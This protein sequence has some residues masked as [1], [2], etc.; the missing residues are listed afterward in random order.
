MSKQTLEYLFVTNI[1]SPYQVDFFNALQARQP[2]SFHVI[3]CAASESDRAFAMPTN[4]KFSMEV[5]ASTHRR[6][7]KDWHRNPE[8][9]DR[10]NTFS[11]RLVIIGGSYFMPD[12]R[13]ARSHCLHRNIPWM[14]WGENPF[15]KGAT[16]VKARL[17]QYYLAHFLAGASGAI[18]VGSAATETYAAFASGRP[19]ANIPYS[20]NLAPLLSPTPEASDRAATLRRQILGSDHGTI[21]LFSGALTE[22]KAPDLLLAAFESI[23]KDLPTVHLVFAGDGPMREQLKPSS[24]RVR[25]LGFLHGD[26][27]ADAYLASDVFVLPSRW[28]EGWGVVVQEA[29]AAGL[30]TIVSDV[31]GAGHDLIESGRSGFRFTSED[32]AALEQQLRQVCADAELRRRMAVAARE[33]AAPTSASFASS[34][35]IEFA[36]QVLARTQEN[37]RAI[38]AA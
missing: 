3:F 18:G 38:T 9:N 29:M 35:F 23:A 30:A 32:R 34:R 21:V 12:A 15:K 33:S 2:G 19:T 16:G 27:L 37:S 25:F 20:P 26:A 5:L 13:T 4:A 22:R 24:D 31:V 1:P 7:M 10:L 11:P 17:K 6:W 8:L 14:Y 28:H 36:E